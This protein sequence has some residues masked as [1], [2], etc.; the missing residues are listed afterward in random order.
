MRRMAE[1]I[2]TE[3]TVAGTGS[4]AGRSLL[5]DRRD[6]TSPGSEGVRAA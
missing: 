5:G 3:H 1:P 2:G 6:H 4:P